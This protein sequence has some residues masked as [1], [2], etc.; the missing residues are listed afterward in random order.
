MSAIRP[1]R[2]RPARIPLVAGVALLIA[3]TAAPVAA[4]SPGPI[5]EA[6]TPPLVGGPDAAGETG[7]SEDLPSIHWLHAQE[8]AYDVV[9]FEAGGR[10]A[11]PF[12]P[13]GGDRWEV[14][15]TVPRELPPGHATGRQMRDAAQD[16]V[17]AA[18]APGRSGEAPGH[19]DGLDGTV[20]QPVVP[21]GAVA[22]PV[23]VSRAAV[24]GSTATDGVEST[25]TVGSGGLRREIFGFLPY[26]ELSD[27]STTLDWRTLSTVA[28]F[29]V[30]CTSNGSLAKR[31]LD[32]S[33]TTGWAGWT[34]SRMTS[35]I[36]A[37]HE[38]GTRV[39]L[40]VSCF[41]WT[42]GGAAIQAAVLRSS[43]ARANLAKQIAA[44]VRDRGADG[45]NLDFEPIV[46]GYADEFTALVRKVRAELNNVARG[47]QLTFD[48]MALIGNQPIAAATAAGGADAVFVMGYDYR[49]AGSAYAG[50]ISPLT[51]PA[52]DLTD[53]VEAFT[54]KVSPSKIILGV[55]YYGRA[56][57]TASDAVH[58][59]TLSPSKYGSSAV[60]LYADAVRFAASYGRRWDA[61]EQAPWTAYRKQTCTAAYGCVTSWR[62]LYYDD[63]TS[64]KRRYDLVNREQLRGV[65][66]WALGF[67]GARTELRAAL[68]AKFL[69]DRT[70]PVVGIE[71]LAQT[72]RDEGFRV[73][74][75]SWD[76]SA[77]AG[78]DVEASADGGPWRRWYTGTKATSATFSGRDGHRYAFRVRA[79]DGHGNVSGWSGAT[80]LTSLGIPSSIRVGGFATVVT[81]GLRMRARPSTGGAI[82]TTLDAGDALKVI[83]GPVT[84]GGYR[85]FQV[86]GPIGEWA[87]VGQP[88]VGGWIAASGNGVVNARPRRPVYATAVNAGITG[89]RLNLGGQRVLTPKDPAHDAV[90]IT[91]TNRL[92]FD[93]LAL[94]VLRFDRSVVGSVKLNATGAG[95][96]AYDWD[97]RVGGSL[98]PA[99]SY[100]LQ[101]EG[102]RGSA[103]YTAPSASPVST[104]QV[105][106]VGVIVGPAVPTSVKS[107][108]STPTSPTRSGD[109][110]YELVFGGA[111][112]DL[113]ATDIS[114]T[115]TAAGCRVATP[116]GSG[117]RWVI[118][119]TGCGA[120]SLQL[121]LRARSVT[122][123]VS[124]TGPWTGI[125][126]RRVIIDRTGPVAARPK[127]A[128]RGGVSVGTAAP[129]ATLAATLTWTATDPG[130]AGVRDF[131]V[132]RSVDG[133]AWST[134]AVAA[135]GSSMSVAMTPGHSYRFQVR[136]R[137]RAGNVGAWVT[138]PTVPVLLRQ[139]TSPS[140]TYAGTWTLATADRYSGGSVRSTS[141]AGASARYSFT[142]RSVGL[143]MTRRPDGGKV[144]V[145]VDGAY[146][147]TIDTAAASLS[148]R[149]VLFTRSWA[150][151]GTHILKLVAVGGTAGRARID[152]DAIAL[153]R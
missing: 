98:V 107:F 145:Y 49:M 77:I 126:A 40:T 120:G 36:N 5:D 73:A 48:T 64:L 122:D 149:Q 44:A 83:G 116:T 14:D 70:P 117:A 26:W 16:S 132:R 28:Y 96:H 57:S 102:H 105:A 58:A 17:W 142:G 37:A 113:R 111:I 93:S 135:T 87:V 103:T 12:R 56:W 95:S 19:A 43:T 30:G 10:V 41:A 106:R 89:L 27:S 79:K 86:T 3:A 25:A 143:V 8:H 21:V 71:T 24:A 118:R 91:W 112:R 50:S 65:G 39:V 59:R 146:V 128:L 151:A 148:F 4:R 11:V 9:A 47:Y 138:G 127:I 130:G 90:R 80:S 104:S 152:L 97:G 114:R 53:T 42:S 121:T 72:Q 136:A 81:D 29:S 129:S 68:A 34:S 141:T 88:Q 115:G 150:S 1:P 99:G 20:D 82:M 85:W 15:G 62:E 61:I 144:R 133:G 123:A 38:H 32:G 124:N 110:T 35:V 46:A 108:T 13:R 78:Y 75:S 92:A 119:V 100:V 18:G 134:L 23:S 131:D 6:G 140:L 76:A 153:L 69:S 63:A 101:L 55:P 67:D 45:V 139:N 74:W 2:R 84:A 54:A 125:A 137:D 66:I 33:T 94:R 109:L 22:A 51:G 147:T 52:Y 7:I 60:P 31:N